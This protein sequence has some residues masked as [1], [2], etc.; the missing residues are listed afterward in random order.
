[1]LG[2]PPALL[3]SVDA[4]YSLWK[5]AIR[6]G[7]EIDKTDPRLQFFFHLGFAISRWAFVDRDLYYI[8]R[9]MIAG[10]S[11]VVAAYLFFKSTSIA[12]HFIA[13]DALVNVRYP[14][15]KKR[16]KKWTGIRKLFNDNISFRN[17]LAHDPVT[18][19]VSAAG[20]SPAPVPAPKWELHIETAKLLRPKKPDD[21]TPITVD[22]IISHIKEVEKLQVAIGKFRNPLPKKPPKRPPESPAPKAPPSPDSGRTK[23]QSRGRRGHPPRSSGA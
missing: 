5:Q 7:S 14:H 6:P 19:I 11:E 3:A 21:D 8:F 9:A 13:T 18:Q 2:S 4:N 20:G 12:D 10:N 22:R 17:R 15:P 1:M 16:A 23:S